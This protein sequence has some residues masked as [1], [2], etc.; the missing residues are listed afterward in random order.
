MKRGIWKMVGVVGMVAC[1]GS[2]IDVGP[3]G[4]GSGGTPEGS[5]AGAGPAAGGAT[6][7]GGGLTCTDTSPLPDWPSSTACAGSS[8]SPVVGK[9]SG[10]VESEG[11]KWD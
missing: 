3:M 11:G 6:S 5:A 4:S 9:W 2:T 10:Y 7:Q 1:S 8:D